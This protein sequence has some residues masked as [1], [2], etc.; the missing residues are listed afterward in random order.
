[1]KIKQKSVCYC[2]FCKKHSLKSLLIHEQHCTMNPD[3]IC[4]LCKQKID[5]RKISEELKS[6][7][8]FERQ[9]DNAIINVKQPTLED[10]KKY[11]EDNC[12]ICILA[13]IRQSGLNRFPFEISF[14]YE[15]ELEKWWSEVNENDREYDL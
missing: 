3:R 13:I 1:M 2:D 4:R 7:M 15:E 12:P 10:I 6:Q 14:D 11:L 8:S 9:E 5:L